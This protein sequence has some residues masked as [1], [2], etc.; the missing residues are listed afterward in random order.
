MLLLLLAFAVGAW[1]E[2][3]SFAAIIIQLFFFIQSWIQK[4]R[5]PV[6][7]F[8]VLL[9]SCLGYLFLMLA[10]SMLPTILK[11]R[12][13]TA[14]WEH[15]HQLTALLRE[16]RWIA[17]AVLF[18]GVMTF[19]WLKRKPDWRS[20]CEVIMFGSFSICTVLDFF[21]LLSTVLSKGFYGVIS[22]TPIGFM[23]L[24]SCF[25]YCLWKAIRQRV[26]KEIILEAVFFSVGGLSALALFVLAMYIPARGFC[27]PVVFVGIATVML[28]NSLKEKNQIAVIAALAVVF[29]VCLTTGIADICRVSV[30]AKERIRAIN[31]A[32]SK[33]GVLIT[34]PYPVRTKYS[35]QYGLLDLAADQ[36]WPNDII[37][38]YYGLKEIIVVS[39]PGE[40]S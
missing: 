21:F 29:T 5:F 30:S 26:R 39:E 2:H 6:S 9:F 28:W 27:A 15:L 17:P 1:S 31:E 22:A 32:V 20:R 14:A 35:A 23:T 38:R 8:S 4:R 19:V 11:S 24:M 7:S 16:N 25:L 3:I 34:S 33:D 18:V 37:M 36:S 13:K 10:P 12:A 40:P